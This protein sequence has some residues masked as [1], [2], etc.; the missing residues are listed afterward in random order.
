MVEIRIPMG[1]A[2][3][4]NDFIMFST[5]VWSMVWVR[6]LNIGLKLLLI[7]DFSLVFIGELSVD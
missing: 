3:Y 5:S 7:E 6:T 2:S 4:L 1:W